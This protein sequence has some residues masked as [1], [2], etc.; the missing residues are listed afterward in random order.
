M[1]EKSLD[2]SRHQE[3]LVGSVETVRLGLSVKGG[4]G[5]RT[6]EAP[7]IANRRRRDN[8]EPGIGIN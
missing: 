6:P 2:E 3:L 5:Q 8:K 7:M 1:K 4:M